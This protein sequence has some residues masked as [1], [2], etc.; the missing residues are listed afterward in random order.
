[1]KLG[2]SPLARKALSSDRAVQPRPQRPLGILPP[3]R[4]KARK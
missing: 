4:L 1:M 2:V 3:V